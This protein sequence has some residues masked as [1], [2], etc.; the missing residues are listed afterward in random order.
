MQRKSDCESFRPS[1][2][3]TVIIFCLLPSVISH[4]ML[5][6]TGALPPCGGFYPKK[7]KAGTLRPRPGPRVSETWSFTNAFS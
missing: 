2:S 6:G 5:C 4:V 3:A 7:Q 1:A